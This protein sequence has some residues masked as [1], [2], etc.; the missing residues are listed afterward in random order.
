MSHTKQVRY[1]L[2]QQTEKRTVLQ[3]TN[4]EKLQLPVLRIISG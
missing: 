4:E 3:M 1:F 2:Y